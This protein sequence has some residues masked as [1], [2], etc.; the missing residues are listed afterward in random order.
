VVDGNRLEELALLTGQGR[1]MPL[2]L[3]GG[4]IAKRSRLD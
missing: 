4:R 3:K 2:I 1:H